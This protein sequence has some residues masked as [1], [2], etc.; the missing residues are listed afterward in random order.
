MKIG[1]VTIKGFKGFET[2]SVSFD[3]NI[4]YLI[5][6]NGSGKSGVGIDAI[7]ACL[8][9]VAQQGKGGN[10]PLISERFRIINPKGRAANIVTQLVEDNGNTINVIRNIT[11]SGQTLSFEGTKEGVTLDQDWLNNLFNQFL[12]APK[13][14]LELSSKEQAIALGIDTSTY[15]AEIKAIKS[16]YTEINAVYRSFGEIPEVTKCE[17]IDTLTLF[18]K[19]EEEQ[20]NRSTK[21]KEIADGLNALYLENKKKNDDAKKLWED[22]KKVI[23]KEVRL[24]NENEAKKII[25]YNACYDANSIL[26]AN[27]FAGTEVENFLAKLKAFMQPQ[28]NAADLYEVEPTCPEPKPDGEALVAFDEETNNLIAAIDV[29]I[30]AANEAN[31]SALLYSQYLEKVEKKAAKK[32]ELDA[33]TQE[34]KD[35]EASRLEYIKAFDLPFGNLSI[36]E[37]G[38][39]LKEGRPIKEP[40]FST[41]ELLKMVPVLISTINPELKY[42]FLQDFNLMDEDKQQEITDYLTDKGFQLVIEYVGKEAITDKNC[43]ILKE[44]KVVE[45]YDVVNKPN[46]AA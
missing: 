19:K 44:C 2:L 26:V 36:D 39:L 3:N 13:K 32:A 25:Q 14:F 42:V 20:K 30:Q 1:G 46:I 12:I 33:N 28:R 9:G 8:Q 35:K 21:R 29:E 5:G 40:H 7:I 37:E 41:G 16:K 45:N 18:E 27:G 6:K 23:D 4:N 11:A 34:Q 24:G 10:K 43:I 31:Q 17:K 15:D 22:G 38:Q